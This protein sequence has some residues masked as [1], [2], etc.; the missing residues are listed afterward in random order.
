MSTCIRRKAIRLPKVVVI[1]VSVLAIVMTASLVASGLK[2]QSPSSPRCS[3]KI[4]GGEK[5]HELP[6]ILHSGSR[7]N[8]LCLIDENGPQYWQ[9]AQTELESVF[10]TSMMAVLGLRRVST[11]Q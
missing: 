10:G 4:D 5:I 3:F 11:S 2:A 1:L 8:V 7:L 6:S 9:E